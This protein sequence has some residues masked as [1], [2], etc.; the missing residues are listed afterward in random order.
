MRFGS[1]VVSLVLGLAVAPAFAASS[2]APSLSPR[3]HDAADRGRSPATVR[4]PV[5]VSLDLHRRAE[6]EAFL[7]EVQDPRSPRYHQFLSQDEFNALYAP[8]PEEE[9]AVVEHLRR[10][11][12]KVTTRVPNRL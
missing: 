6:L 8:T 9:A 1:V 4:H 3:L 10:G 7:V 2:K 12:L 5:L 11:G